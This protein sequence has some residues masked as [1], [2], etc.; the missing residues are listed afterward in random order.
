VTD[1]IALVNMQFEGRHGVLPEEQEVPQ[2]FEVDAE[3]F[4]DLRTAAASDDVAQ[5]ADY[6][7]VFDICRETVEGQS[8]RLIETVADTIASRLLRAFRS[9]GVTKV[10]VNVRKPAVLLPGVL[11]AASVEV[12]RTQADIR[13]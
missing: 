7:K 12:R 8:Y 10:Q 9:V 2:P 11:D 1:R 4:L 3:L 6:R 13:E 5:T